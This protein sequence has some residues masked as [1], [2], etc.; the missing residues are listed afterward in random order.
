MEPLA[1]ATIVRDVE[2]QASCTLDDEAVILDFRSGTYYGLNE[3]GARVWQLIEQPR[4]LD[5]L[6]RT[7]CAEYEVDPGPC[8]EDLIGLLRN[9]E[10]AGLIKLEH[11]SAA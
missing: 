8:R 5:E 10:Q 7:I 4:T 3:V 6:V 11:E 2:Q 1:G 9:L